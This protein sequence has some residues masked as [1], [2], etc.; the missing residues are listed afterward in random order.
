MTQLSAQSFSES[1]IRT[2]VKHPDAQTRAVA[3]QRICHHVRKTEL[4]DT[5]RKLAHD[6]LAFMARDA[7][8]LVRRALAVTLKNSP[9]LPHDVAL[10]LAADIDSIAVPVLEF[11]PVFTDE[12]LV[13]VLRSRAAAKVCAVAKRPSVSGTIVS[14]IVRYGDSKSVAQLAANDGADISPSLA[15]HILDSYRDDDL[16]S[17]AM[18]SRKDLPPSVIERLISQVSAEAAVIMTEQYDVAPDIAIEIAQNS[19]ERATVDLIDQSWKHKD[20]KLLCVRL[21]AERR[22]TESLIVRAAGRGH[23]RFAEHALAL[24]AGIRHAKAVLMVHDNGPFGLQVLC[25]RAQINPRDSQIIRA[26][27]Q[28]YHDLEFSAVEYDQNYFQEMMMTRLLTLPTEL[29]EEDQAYFLDKLD[30]LE[31]AKAA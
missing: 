17:Q 14:N 7:A 6:L 26:A 11:S 3:A 8:D 21:A 28:I 10:Q 4:T 30:G 18:V 29:A 19:R 24:R 15:A 20:L 22:L 5:E 27:I 13:E 9:D 16:I 2:L 23:M 12:D 25:S 1:D 31:R